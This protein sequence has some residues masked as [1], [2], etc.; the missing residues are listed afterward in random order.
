M[1]EQ[2]LAT[3]N[4][5]LLATLENSRKYTLSVA[6]AMPEASYSFK[7]TE[8]VWNFGELLNHIAYGIQWWEANY[9]KGVQTDWAPPAAKASR[10]E[11]IAY[12]R[13]AY[14]GLR[15]T[16]E[17]GP[18]GDDAIKGFHATT[19]HI[20]HHRGQA[21]IYLRCKGITPPEYVY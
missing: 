4:E 3:A 18:L 16:L 13:D 19:D 5:Q 6:E 8:S 1:K 9:V 17:K 20:T 14:T 7:P 15:K 10:Q 12:L 21:V 11:T 2:L